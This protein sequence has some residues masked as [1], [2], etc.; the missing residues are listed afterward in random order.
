MTSEAN[1][2]RSWPQHYDAQFRQLALTLQRESGLDA[3]A[4]CRREGI[5]PKTSYRR[6]NIGPGGDN[7]GQPTGIHGEVTVL[8]VRR[9]LRGQKN[10][11]R[12]ASSRSMRRSAGMIY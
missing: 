11:L 8:S 7:R 10:R 4:F 9:G 2:K 12:Q 3:V 5:N 1:I 6:R